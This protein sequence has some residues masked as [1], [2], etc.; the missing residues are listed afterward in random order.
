VLKVGVIG[1]GHLGRYHADKYKALP[2]VELI[3]VADI[4]RRRAE[5][6]AAELGVRAFY[7]HREMIGLV[8]AVNVVVPTQD[9]FPVAKDFIEAGVHVLVEKPIARTLQEAD[10]MIALA[11]RHKVVL[12]VGHLER[13]NPAIT[14]A[15]S[16]IG[17][18]LFIEANRISPFP[19]RGTDVDVVLDL[20]IH[21]LDISLMLVREDPESVRAVGVPVVSSK[22]DIAN[23]R[24]EFPGGCV[25]NLTAS[26][27]SDKSLRK[28][29]IFQ[30]DAYLSID[31]AQRQVNLIRQVL[32]GPSGL[33]GVQTEALS[34]P[35]VDA[36]EEEIKAFVKAVME[37]GVPAVTG[38]DGR[39]ALAAALRIMAEVTARQGDWFDSQEREPV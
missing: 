8:E 28:I 9:H 17:R 34:I 1:V 4:S 31:Y 6:K 37:S 29:R 32:R 26:R 39:R 2:G 7:D 15:L 3:G 22:V 12:Q 13:F 23:A 19:Q 36:L 20:M 35:Q 33:P 18:P 11:D 14:A 24:L 38:Q 5:A 10:A 25:A 30:R 21:D 16:F 27:I